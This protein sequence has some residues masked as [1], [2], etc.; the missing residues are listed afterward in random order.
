MRLKTEIIIQV[1]DEEGGE[2]E[3]DGR[4]GVSVAV[5]ERLWRLEWCG[6]EMDGG[7]VVVKW[8]EVVWW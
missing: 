4:M 1:N 3:E 7:G 2:K 8:V 5:I 6:G